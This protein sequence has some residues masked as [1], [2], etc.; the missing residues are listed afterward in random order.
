MKKFLGIV[1]IVIICVLSYSYFI[2]EKGWYTNFLDKGEL[3][4][5]FTSN[6]NEIQYKNNN[7]DSQMGL[8]K[9]IPR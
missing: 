6:N 3:E 7:D 2:F 4:V 5:L 1:S 8:Y 9:L